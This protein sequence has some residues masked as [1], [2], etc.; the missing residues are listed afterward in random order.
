MNRT[1]APLS[2]RRGVN[3]GLRMGTRR[4]ELI[5]MIFCS[6]VASVFLCMQFRQDLSNCVLQVD[7]HSVGSRTNDYDSVDK[8]YY[9]GRIGGHVD[10]NYDNGD[11]IDGSIHSDPQ[12]TKNGE[13]TTII[14]M[15]T[16]YGLSTFKRFVGSL[17]NTG[18]EGH[19]I[20]GV[21]P[22]GGRNPMRYKVQQY[23]S[24]RNV[25][26]KHIKYVPCKHKLGSEG[27]A[28]PYP[29]IKL[30]WSRFPLA[31]D[32]LEE[33]A[34]CT[35]PVLI[36]DVRDSIFQENPFGSTSDGQGPPVVEGLQVFEENFLQTTDHWLVESRVRPCKNV[37]F[38]CVES[39]NL[40]IPS[41]CFSLFFF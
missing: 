34:T 2:R 36:M 38:R 21:S 28:H 26:M 35:G 16:N 10:S 30:R 40:E 13:S 23:L 14:G 24:S 12:R 11:D 27:C 22:K 8:F 9:D 18:Y 5:Q 1:S 7:H 31:R 3:A 29:D 33:C 25:T 37:T 17:R 39:M 20:L 41:I 32:W 6:V 4:R 15:A 19:I